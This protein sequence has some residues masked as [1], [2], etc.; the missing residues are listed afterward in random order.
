MKELLIKQI[1]FEHWANSTLL[2][3][4]REANPLDDRALLLFSHLLS[5]GSMWLSRLLATPFTTTIF[6]ERTLAECEVLM[7]QNTNGWLA[8]L[9]QADDKE[10]N[11]IVDFI[12]PIDGSNKRMA[13][14]DAVMHVVHHSSYHR[15]QLIARIKGSVEKLPLVTYIVYASEN[16]S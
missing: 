1:N 11:R 7:N 9:Q 4:M 2:A 12:F 8:Y 16:V 5:S 14:A 13:V 10:L 15:G 6:Q 3:A